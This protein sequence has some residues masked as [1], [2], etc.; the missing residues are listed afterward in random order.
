MAAATADKVVVE[1]E[2]RDSAYQARVRQ[3]ERAFTDSQ[4]KIARSAEDAERRIRASSDGIASS[5]RS[6]A[7]ALAA[8][9]TE[10]RG[11]FERV[12]GA[13]P[14]VALTAIANTR[15]RACVPRLWT[16]GRVSR[17]SRN[18]SVGEDHR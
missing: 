10:R 5:L 2:L 14:S 17:L 3:S 16:L 6:S 13:V 9:N 12:A 18:D 15:D 7:A 11:T 4:K 8:A 1:L